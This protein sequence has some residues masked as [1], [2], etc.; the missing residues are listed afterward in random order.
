LITAADCPPVLLWDPVAPVIA[1]VHSGWRGT[2][3]EIAPKTLRALFA[4]G[5]KPERIRAAIGP[6]IGVCC[7]EVGEEV[8]DAVPARWRAK[9]L[10][11]ETA[12]ARPS[13]DLRAWIE[14]QLLD[15]GI[16]DANIE[17]MDRCT[18]C[19]NGVFF[20]HRAERGQCGRFGLA[21]ALA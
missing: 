15:C 13:L 4:R 16:A 2:A 10:H 1:A 18:S 9:L 3:A 12:A 17:H 7:Y 20:S 21:A 5:A 6:G 14:M 19:D 8:A 11:H